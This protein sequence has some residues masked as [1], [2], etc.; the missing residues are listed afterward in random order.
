MH[1][2]E[3]IDSYWF[4]KEQMYVQLGHELST[5]FWSNSAAAAAA[6]KSLSRVRLC[7]TPETTA[8]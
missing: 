2:A 6:A 7:V 8:N 1:V 5:V 4:C 3:I